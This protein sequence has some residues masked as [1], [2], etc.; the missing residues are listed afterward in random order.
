MWQVIAL[1]RSFS[2]GIVVSKSGSF[3]VTGGVNERS[4]ILGTSEILE[5]PKKTKNESFG[6]TKWTKGI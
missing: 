4:K 6:F 3:L 1:F 2:S 5:I